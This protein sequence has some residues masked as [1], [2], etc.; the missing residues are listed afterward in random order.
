M[1]FC[2]AAWQGLCRRRVL[3]R[4]LGWACYA[5]V[6]HREPG[7]VHAA[8]VCSCSAWAVL[9][10]FWICTYNYLSKISNRVTLPS[11]PILLMTRLTLHHNHPNHSC[12]HLPCQNYCTVSTALGACCARPKSKT[13]IP[14]TLLNLKLATLV[15]IYCN[16]IC[17]IILPIVFT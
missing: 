14:I 12:F 9:F 5:T 7:L 6:I 1:L 15:Q 8:T 4:V 13:S 3:W 16:F 2:G 17:A 10:S 11:L